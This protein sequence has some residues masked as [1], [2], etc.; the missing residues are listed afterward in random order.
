MSDLIYHNFWVKAP[1]HLLEVPLPLEDFKKEDGTYMNVVEYQASKGHTVDRFSTDGYFLKGFSFNYSGLKELEDKVGE[2]GL[3]IGKN[4]FILTAN[5]V[6]QELEKD[7][8]NQ[9][10]GELNG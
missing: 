2:F 4:I 9:D 5:E 7:E 3:E 1:V 6:Q 8:W 10:E